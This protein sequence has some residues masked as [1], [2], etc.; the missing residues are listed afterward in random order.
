MDTNTP[1]N[2]DSPDNG[3]DANNTED[4]T[5]AEDF[6]VHLQA[7][8]DRYKRDAAAMQAEFNTIEEDDSP[9]AVKKALIAAV[10]Q[11]IQEI[12]LL[13]QH[14]D[15]EGVRL[16]ASKYITDVALGKVKI[17]ANSDGFDNLIKGLMQE[18]ADNKA[19]KKKNK[20]D[21]P[22][23]TDKPNTPN[24]PGSGEL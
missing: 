6:N 9:A 18:T 12:I 1:K 22:T 14:G 15:S 20:Q 2:N 24:V 10:P 17:E 13:S 19:A 8:L 11:A 21:A 23:N 7:E 3:D 4:V 16:N 5:S